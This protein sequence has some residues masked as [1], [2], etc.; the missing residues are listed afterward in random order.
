M[1]F[2]LY[3]VARLDAGSRCYEQAGSY[4]LAGNRNGLIYK[5][6]RS[7]DPERETDA[8]EN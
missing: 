7:R 2:L 3:S 4:S 5:A 6:C 1:A 8:H